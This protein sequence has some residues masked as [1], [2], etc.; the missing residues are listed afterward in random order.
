M[1]NSPSALFH[2]DEASLGHAHPE[3]ALDILGDNTYIRMG[4]NHPFIVMFPKLVTPVGP[5]AKD[6]MHS[7]A[8]QVISKLLSLIASPSGRGLHLARIWDCTIGLPVLESSLQR[9]VKVH[10]LEVREYASTSEWRQQCRDKLD[11]LQDQYLLSMSDLWRI[12]VRL[13]TDAT[14][15][16]PH[17]LWEAKEGDTDGFLHTLGDLVRWMGPHFKYVQRNPNADACAVMDFLY[18]ECCAKDSLLP[19]LPVQLAGRRLMDIL[20][21]THMLPVLDGKPHGLWNRVDACLDITDRMACHQ[22]ATEQA[23]VRLFRKRITL[24]LDSGQFQATRL[25]CGR[26]R[27]AAVIYDQLSRL[28]PAVAPLSYGAVASKL[29]S[30]SS[31]EWLEKFAVKKMGAIKQ[32]GL[33]TQ[34]AERV[35]ALLLEHEIDAADTYTHFQGV[36]VGTPVGHG[37]SPGATVVGAALPLYARELQLEMNSERYRVLEAKLEALKCQDTRTRNVDHEF[38]ETY[39]QVWELVQSDAGFVHKWML[40]LLDSK[41]PARPIFTWLEPFRSRWS[42]FAAIKLV[43]DGNS[44]ITPEILAFTLPKKVMEDIRQGNMVNRINVLKDIYTPYRVQI[45]HAQDGKVFDDNQIY[46]DAHLRAQHKLFADRMY[47]LSG[48]KSAAQVVV[49][50]SYA[51]VV[52]TFS[53]FVEQGDALGGSRR[54][55]HRLFAM[56]F[57]DKARTEAAEAFK[58]ERLKAPDQYLQD[59]SKAMRILSAKMLQLV[60]LTELLGFAPE[61]LQAETGTGESHTTGCM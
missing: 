41:A 1:P 48:Y 27:V 18:R 16:V 56:D 55:A 19:T 52:D 2:F 17:L 4:L 30:E 22:D 50:N 23:R 44:V 43:W 40:K 45:R 47:N 46:E 36:G 61:L 6:L 15:W 32:M 58:R 11:G 39:F 38:E 37:T 9:A 25:L 12:P 51:A 20:H 57:I 54:Q 3:L 33:N 14:S 10:G 42:E 29:V 31:L 59:G 26:E 49:P 8:F 53:H 13:D 21:E 28:M 7:P 60:Q 5:S 35:T 34:L 24:A